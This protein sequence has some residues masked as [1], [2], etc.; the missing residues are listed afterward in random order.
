MRSRFDYVA[1]DSESG[2][3]QAEIKEK[4]KE[5]EAILDFHMGPT[6][7]W[8]GLAMDHIEIAYMAAGKELRDLQIL[9]DDQ[10]KLQEG[11]SQ[12]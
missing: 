6:S 8:R 1:Y 9:R 11:R 12:S 7:R 10:T 4:F 2:R 5:V 3:A